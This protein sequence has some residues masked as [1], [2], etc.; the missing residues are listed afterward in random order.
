M[1]QQERLEVL[2]MLAEGKINAREAEILLRAIGSAT[3]SSQPSSTKAQREAKELFQELSEEIKQEVAKAVELVQRSNIGKIVSEV[4]NDVVT[5][6]KASVST[7][8]DECEESAPQEKV[9][10]TL[11]WT[12]D[13][14]GI[15]KIDAQTVNGSIKL[16]GADDS[17]IHVSAWK[18]VSGR[19]PAQAE[20]FAQQV[21]VYAERNGDEIRIYREH[22][23]PPHGVSV[24]VRYEIECP[25]L[26]NANLRTVNSKIE[27][28]GIDGAV[29]V[30]TVNG[31]IE[32]QCDTGPVHAQT[33]NGGIEAAIGRLEHESKFS[34]TNG[35]VEVS[36][37]SGAAGLTATTTNGGIDV[38]LPE[39]FSG[40]LDARTSNGRVYSDF[41][42][43]SA[44]NI[45]NRL[46]GQ[47]GE[48]QG[49]AIVKLRSLNGSIYL[50]KK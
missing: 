27:A 1:S 26:M 39:T 8:V 46:E 25:V 34:T 45:R 31:D 29:D 33:T 40:Q 22:P 18:V 36:V 42:I 14:A 5:Q 30:T 38:T 17:S 37:D 41:P 6:V 20:A 43:P 35:G 19:D 24:N 28:S 7:I 10:E 11:S 16:E 32:L 21:K 15:N 2:K 44:G 50:R 4:V 3:A 12:F 13:S 48:G 9:E 49:A 23:K 47:I